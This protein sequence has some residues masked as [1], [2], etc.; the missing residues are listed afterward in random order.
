M[1][2]SAGDLVPAD[3]RL[4]DAKDLHL[5][6]AALTGESLPV[7]KAPRPS[8]DTA[9]RAALDVHDPDAVFLGT[10]VV[11]GTATAVVA[12]TGPRTVFGAV[13]R[14]LSSRAPVTE[15]DRG[16]LRFGAF[17]LKTVVFLVLFVFL[18][19]A[20][21]HRDALQSLLFAVAL[22]VGLTP[23]FLPMITTVTLG[24]GAQRMAKQRVIVKNLAAIQNLGSIDVLCCDKTG[25]LTTGHMTLEAHV[26]ARGEPAERP[27]LFAFVNSAFESG[28]DDAVDD[29]VL[30]KVHVDP[31]DEAVLAHP[32]PDIA[33]Y[34]KIDEV[35]FDFER[36]RVSVVVEREG[37]RLL[38]TKGAPEQ[39][40]AACSSWDAKGGPAPLDGEARARAAATFTALG[41]Q[42]Y[43]V[44]AVATKPLPAGATFTKADE[45]DLTLI[46]FLGFA[47]PPRDDACDA[48]A[49]L[50]R[51][52][53]RVKVVTG[54]SELVAGHVC[55]RASAS[56]PRASC[57]GARSTR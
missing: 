51:A 26:D 15:F 46:G 35:P 5:N 40:L 53:V 29:A 11:S 49:E 44:L 7:E 19:C 20:A 22:A 21:L 50:G 41:A 36:R 31:L 8:G 34:R 30:R 18:A 9:P 48:V 54:D 14:T 1:K 39:L 42:G 27:L 10:S 47:D 55:G 6:E 13:A 37:A 43:R 28:V 38:V 52:G 12:A 33:G 3:A 2:L 25:T 16:I 56:T 32:H 24:R 17:I 45:K 57:S 4:L 23:E